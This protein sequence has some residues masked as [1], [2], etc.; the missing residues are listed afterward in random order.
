MNG[1][2]PSAFSQATEALRSAARSQLVAMAYADN[3]KV[4]YED[5]LGLKPKLKKEMVSELQAILARGD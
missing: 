3:L 2:L 5:H 4:L 1:A